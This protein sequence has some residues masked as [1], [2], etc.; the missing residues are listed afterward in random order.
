M[1]S[2]GTSLIVLLCT[3]GGALT[4]MLIRAVLPAHH[5]GD[6]A[7]GAVN[8]AAATVSVLTALVISSLVSSA[9]VAFETTAGQVQEFSANLVLLDR[10]MAHY[11]P[12][13]DE[14]RDLL[15]RYTARKIELTWPKERAR[16]PIMDDP[17]ALEMLETVQDKLRALEPQSEAQH[18][19]KSRALQVSGDL[20][21]VRWKLA[22]ENEGVIP[23]P[24]LPA[25][26][27]DGGGALAHHPLRQFRA[28]RA[29]Q[30]HRD[31]GLVR[32]RALHRRGD[33]SDPGAG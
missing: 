5:F 30:P 32:E 12:E 15:R 18:W 2:T 13:I 3:F 27:P 8:L 17:A 25:P 22:V 6:D 21:Q 23:R 31:H 24:F 4:G 20:A 9:R 28:L 1:L 33:R 14:A 19:L 10:V 7:K 29:A 16:K 26:L 11:G